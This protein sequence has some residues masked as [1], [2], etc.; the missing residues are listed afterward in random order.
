MNNEFELLR[1]FRVTA[2]SS[3]FRD[4]AVRL[5][6]SPQCVTR[7]IQRLERH[8]G[9]VLFHRS[10][11]QVRITAFGEGLLEQVRPAIDCLEAQRAQVERVVQGLAIGGVQ[12]RGGLVEHVH[13]TEQQGTQLR[14]QPQALQ[15]AGRKRRRGPV[16]RQ[17]A[18]A[19]PTQLA[20]V[21]VPM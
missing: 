6:T 20:L 10:T 1:I 9:E 3:S 11:R 4:A 2:E 16:Q 12:A 18:Q 14:G 8:Y 13:D 19:Q 5:G 17:V 15:L 21:K 7:A